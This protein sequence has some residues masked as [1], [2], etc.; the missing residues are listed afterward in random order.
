MTAEALAQAAPGFAIEES[1]TVSGE[2]R[3]ARITLSVDGEIIFNVYPAPDRSRATG[4]GTRSA[5]ARG[6]EG[7]TIGV[8]RFGA[9]GGVDRES[10]RTALAHER[11]T[12]SCADASGRFWRAYEV[13]ARYDGARDTFAAIPA[14]VA[15]GAVLAQM[16][17]VAPN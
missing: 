2:R 4:I 11:F 10:C 6:P 13:A 9:T 7:E 8:T 3:F 17:W 12:F 15:D 5:R 14:E 1:E 16:Y